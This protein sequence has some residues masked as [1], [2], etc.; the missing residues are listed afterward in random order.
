MNTLKQKI[1]SR[2]AKIGILGLGYVGLPLAAEFAKKGFAVTGFDVN[3]KRVRE[4]ESGVSSIAD[5]PSET[6]KELVRTG[7]LGA[8]RD[9]SKLKRQDAIIVCVPTP[10]R[11]TKDPD[12]SHILSASKAIASNLRKG[13]LIILESTTY[14]GTTRELILPKLEADGFKCGRDFFLAFSPERV[15][16]GNK[17]YK[18]PN[19]PKV[20]G[21]M[22]PKA[23]ELAA[24]LYGTIVEKV[25]SV[26][27]AE[28]AEMVK[29]LENTFRAINIGLANEIALMCEKLNL[30]VWEIV[31][32]AATKPFGYMPFYPGPGWG[33][34]CIPLDPHYLAWKMKALNFEPRFIEL[35]SSINSSM[36]EYVVRRA[37]ELL[38][39]R[40]IPLK[41]SKILVLGVAYKSDVSDT[42]ESPALDVIE[43]LL[44]QGARVSYHDP[45]VPELEHSHCRM[46][47]APLTPKTLKNSDLA[48]I[49]TAHSKVDYSL[50]VKH[51]PM[52]FDTRNAAKG[53]KSPKLHRL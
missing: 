31:E 48:L 51:A 15:D 27:C 2:K 20:V 44:H 49:V 47:S 43:H 32:A 26:S 41:G 52:V 22:E 39:S 24:L 35:A 40:K 29:L 34:H 28:A 36:P 42:R 9:F 7:K 11:K 6:V 16:P 21:G 46:I 18:I 45:Y 3:S 8:T 53:I 14:P 38:N 10:L 12:V 25:V 50:V 19:T 4:V 13:Q 33:G 5:V 17:T 23:T 37:A 30:N 1:S